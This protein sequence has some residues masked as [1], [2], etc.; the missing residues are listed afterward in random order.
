MLY[1]QDIIVCGY[2]IFCL[3]YVILSPGP[4]VISVINVFGSTCQ[5]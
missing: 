3:F 4:S 2:N 1:V 5:K